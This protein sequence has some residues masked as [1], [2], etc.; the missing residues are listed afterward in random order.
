[1]PRRIRRS[2]HVINDLIDC[3][4][5]LRQGDPAAAE[6]FL[7]AAEEMLRKLGDM[8]GLGRAWKSD[9]PQLARIR[10]IHLE[11][12]FDSYLVFYREDKHRVR[13]LRVVHG[14]RDILSL[15]G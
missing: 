12:P 9:N 13:I 4:R 1:M 6:R 11:L 8:P 5:Y 10:V 15:L 14:A 2:R 7:T 3:Y